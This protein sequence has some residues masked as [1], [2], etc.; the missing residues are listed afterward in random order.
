MKRL[1]VLSVVLVGVFAGLV[2]AGN[3]GFGPV[4]ITREDQQKIVLMFGEVRAVTQ[5]GL[6]F[7]IPLLETV[8]TFDRRWLHLT[9]EELPIQTNDGEQLLIDDYVIWRIDDPVAFR[10][11]FPGGMR[12]AAQRID[13]TVRDDVREAIGRH[14]RMEVLKD[15]TKYGLD[16]FETT[17]AE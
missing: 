1:I 6:S 10:R 9:S 3:R 8:Q 11:A 2:A 7:R 14:T 17:P 16:I 4:V 13:R 5:P 15:K 12:D